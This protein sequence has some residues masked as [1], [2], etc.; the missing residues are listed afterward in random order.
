MLTLNFTKFP[1]LETERLIL[2]E[3]A[4]SD[5]ETL[6][7]MRTNETVMKYIY[8][9]RPKNIQEIEA[10]ISSFNI[11]FANGDNLAWVIAL[12]ENPSQMVGSL[13]YWRTDYANHRAEIGY[14]LHPNYWRMGIVSEALA[15]TITFG[16]KN[17]NLHS[18]C[19]NVSPKNNASQQIL[20]KHG[21][22]KE[23][24][25]KQNYYFRGQFLDSEIYGLL[26]PG[27]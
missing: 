10:F 21:F 12:K 5:A 16:F 18:I 11:G 3:H 25:F 14:M 8:R 13:G 2:R 22:K 20:I 15:K 7:A 27:H 19:A 9:E 1:V 26:N 6:F 17:M 4:L 23:A 24:H